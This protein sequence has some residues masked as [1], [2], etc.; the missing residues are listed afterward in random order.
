MPEILRV[1]RKIAFGGCS[2]SP[3]VQYSL[4]G[5]CHAD[6]IVKDPQIT[7]VG[8]VANL[9]RNN[10]LIVDPDDMARIYVD[11]EK[12]DLFVMGRRTLK[13]FGVEKKLHSYPI[14]L[15][16][17][18]EYALYIDDFDLNDV[19][20]IQKLIENLKKSLCIKVVLLPVYVGCSGHGASNPDDLRKASYELF[21]FAKALNITPVALA[22]PTIPPD[23]PD[24]VIPFWKIIPTIK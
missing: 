16:H 23:L 22:H 1:L 7:V 20:E 10:R 11:C 12:L 3:F 15:K 6:H 4:V 13:Q 14:L 9:K 19:P 5:H 21:Y 8:P 17:E 2:A 24:F 18:N